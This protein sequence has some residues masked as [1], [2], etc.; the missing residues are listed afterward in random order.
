MKSLQL[1]PAGFFSPITFK[2]IYVPS[3]STELHHHHQLEIQR[4]RLFQGMQ[5]LQLARV[6]TPTQRPAVR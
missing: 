2:E 5:L 1:Y 4:L 6:T 3:I